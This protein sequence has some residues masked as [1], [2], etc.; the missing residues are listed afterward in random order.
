[1]DSE[2]LKQTYSPAGSHGAALVAVLAVLTILAIMAAVFAAVMNI[3]HSISRASIAKVQ[4][5]MLAKSAIEHTVSLLRQDISEQPAWDD[6]SEDW[7]SWFRPGNAP[8]D[9]TVDVDGVPEILD[10][11][12][13]STDARWICVNNEEGAVVGRY[14]VLVE[15]EAAKINVN[16]AAALSPDMQNQGVDT[17]EIM[18]TDGKRA[19]LPISTERGRRL[20]NY[21]YGRD[22]QPGQAGAD[23]NLTEAEY[24]ADEIDNDADSVRDER[25]EGI[26]EQN[27]FFAYRPGW[28]DRAFGNI[29]ELI[30]ACESH[31]KIPEAAW[32]FVRKYGTVAS[33]SHETYWDT[34]ESAWHS[35]LNVNSATRTQLNKVL[36]RANQQVPFESSSRKLRSLAVNIIDYRDE[37]HA[38]STL[39][40]EYGVEA[41]CF[42][43]IMA[44]DGSYT[45]RADGGSVYRFG[46]WYRRSTDKTLCW[47]I[48]SV[49]GSGGGGTALQ[50]GKRVS[51]PGSARIR[52]SDKPR[53]FNDN[54][55]KNRYYE[56]RKQYDHWPRDLWKNSTLY[57]YD[58]EQAAGKE[59]TAYPVLSS[60]ADS[61]TVG[62]NNATDA[63][64]SLLATVVSP[65]G[66]YNAVRLDNTWLHSDGIMAVYPRISEYFMVA[67]KEFDEFELPENLYYT[68][69][70]GEQ[71]L[72]GTLHHGG[73]PPNMPRKGFWPYLDVDGNPGTASETRML[74]ITREEESGNNWH[75]PEGEDRVWLLRTP[76]KDGEPIQMRDGFLHVVVSS[77][78]NCGYN[79]R[80]GDLTAY[81]NKNIVQQMY[82]MRP[83]IIELI[84][85][86]DEPISLRNWRVVIN[87]GS[88]A[89]QVA[90]IDSCSYYSP[91]LDGRYQ[92][93]NP[94]I[95]P[96]GYFY[97]TNMRAVF[98]RDYG[99]P[100]DGVW[101]SSPAETYPV[102]ELPNA[103]WG[104]RYHVE[105]VYANKIVCKGAAWKKDQMKYEITEWHMYKARPDQ[106]SSLGI[107]LTIEGNTRN[108]LDM[109]NISVVSL[110]AG[111]NVLIIGMP[112]EGGFLSMTLKNAYNQITARTITYGSTS[113]EEVNYSTEKLD[114]THY[115]WI[116]S[117]EP[118]FGG[119]ERGA[120]NHS[121][122]NGAGQAAHVKDSRFTSIGEVLKV[123]RASDWENVGTADRGES[124]LA[125]KA[126]SKY[127][128][129]SGIRLDAEEKGVHVKGWQPGFGT[130]SRPGTDVVSCDD[131]DWEPG[132]WKGH[133]L[134][135]L[136]GA[137][138]TEEFII[139]N[140]TR[141][142]I[143]TSGHSTRSTTRLVVKPGDRFCVGPGY[144]TP[145]YYTRRSNDEG[146][147][148]WQNKHLERKSYGLY[149]F[150]LNDSISTTEFLEE[151]HNAE[152]SVAVFNFTTRTYD[153]LP[154][155]GS[156]DSV[157]FMEAYPGSA[158]MTYD[159]SDGIYCGM[160]QPDHISPGGG[161]RLRLISHN[162]EHQDCSGFAWFDY[163][164]LTP[165]TATGK[166]NIN[167][168]SPR[169]LSALKNITP[170]I[171]RNISRGRDTSG[172]DILKP[173]R[174]VS[175]LLDVA[176]FTPDIYKDICNLVTI[177]S[178]QFRVAVLAQALSDVDRDGSFDPASGD[179][180]TSE[181]F[182]EVVID[183]G[184]LTDGNPGTGRM[185]ILQ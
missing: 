107:R 163:A 23:D 51:M 46:D 126:L 62:Y 169:V 105:D 10:R 129:F 6:M 87:T 86:S 33:E 154:V 168:A 91:A 118:T 22:N 59:W 88:Y 173:Y 131:A 60:D 34:R 161:I 58:E 67:K 39:G 9:E 177:R 13:S 73:C 130:V 47:Q 95:E 109:G 31:V 77:T 97:L 29:Q 172:R 183:R 133:K 135:M 69:Y 84:N 26:D 54:N 19:G 136:S 42:N 166:I 71:N 70:L 140:N 35:K 44:N 80:R 114:P 165:G 185:R 142:S 108:I 125:L 25:N 83:D 164:F 15:D 96:G 5:D 127:C 110:K 180:V 64:Y 106:N 18:L 24:S 138:K 151:N 179:T 78:G 50:K 90:R 121:F 101:G 94:V 3:N 159:K 104:V 57:V 181:S 128:T 17:F 120:R 66:G 113:L 123:R 45:L 75:L 28:D 85:I 174:D 52:L 141:N 152:L 76:Y 61:L 8:E 119:S 167:T 92:N 103:L 37:N 134:I 79:G 93:P 176:G 124:V 117:P 122:R 27:E 53:R 14:A 81:K 178:D 170:L 160:I 157:G 98:D 72:P 155:A 16:A 32:K 21:R 99:T 12:A 115:T 116:K 55:E 65:T 175:D 156:A 2:K 139:T 132:I 158:R 20:L 102:Y 150:G 82:M 74:E 30:S 137:A 1:M 38:L 63:D 56:F 147:W 153:V 100:Q 43:E 162:L 149:L 184:E 36:H 7:Y 41:I 48:T 182:K 112:R 89:D 143:Y 171:A 40:S 146:I 145:L 111:D 11:N 4:S 148:E 144:C 68:V 49:A